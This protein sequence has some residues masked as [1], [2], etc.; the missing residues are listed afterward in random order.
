[1]DA[2]ACGDRIHVE[3]E[4]CTV[5]QA[6]PP[7]T[8]PQQPAKPAH[9]IYLDH[10]ATTPVLP[11]VLDAMVPWFSAQYGNPS[12]IHTLGRQAH[13]GLMQA[14]RSIANLLG[15][16]PSEV[17]FTSCGSEAD[18]AALRGIAMARRE[19]TS[20]RR[21]VISGIEH[22]AVLA[23]AEQLRD[24]FGFELTVLPMTSDGV[25][26][27]ARVEE[28][29]AAG[30]VALVSVVLASNEI[31]TVQPMAG[32]GQICRTHGV[33]LHTDAVQAAGR[34]SLDVDELGVDA[35]SASAHKFYGPK[36]A[37]FLYLRGG[38]PF[39]PVQTGG[40][41]EGGRRAGTENVPLIVGMARALEIA[42]A[43]RE[44]EGRRLSALRDQL[45]GGVL[46]GVDGASLTGS[47]TNRLA[48]H[49]SFVVDGVEAEG[50]LIALDLAGIAASSGSA[51]TSAAHEPSHV[52]VA[53]GVPTSQAAG[54]L[55][56]TLGRSTTPA[57]IDSLLSVLPEIVRRA[58][59]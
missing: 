6:I 19:R 20:A 2:V 56:F 40:G 1:M 8:I 39:L 31:G 47:A 43:D 16:R 13:A 36:G 51:C 14:R 21:I 41:H 46:E 7:M 48:H 3:S 44:E 24:H 18:N 33:P 22:K 34:L 30:D 42:E 23:T 25:V 9:P 12:S 58:R 55:R 29:L 49:A 35:L 17:I 37:G 57:E 38:T 52:L 10:S 11:D 28:A 54:G 53:I 26:E 4:F 50:I 15:A 59:G 5:I 27:P 32:I 45:I